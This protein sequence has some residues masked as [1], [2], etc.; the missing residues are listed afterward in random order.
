MW[1]SLAG[2]N[3]AYKKFALQSSNM[4]EISTADKAVDGY[5]YATCA[6]TL[7]SSYA[8]WKVSLGKP[9]LVTG[10]KIHSTERGG[11]F[12]FPYLLFVLYLIL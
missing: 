9:Y 8:W 10:I 2:P 7:F 4:S 11:R 1:L 5:R 3:V 6:V 12:F